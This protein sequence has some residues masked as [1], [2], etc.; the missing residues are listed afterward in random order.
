MNKLILLLLFFASFQM[1]GQKVKFKKEN[2]LVG[3]EKWGGIETEIVGAKY[4]FSTLQGQ[5]FVT[6]TFDGIETGQYDGNGKAIEEK[7][8]VI[9]FLGVNM[10]PFETQASTRKQVV[11]WLVKTDVIQNGQFSLEQAQI[12]KE[13][14]AYDVSGK[15]K[16][17]TTIIIDGQ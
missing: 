10:D 17:G 16:K 6:M 14:Y 4:T 1:V 5:E 15:Y 13:K 8:I 11:Q 9:K 2:I 3:G 12:F 7:F